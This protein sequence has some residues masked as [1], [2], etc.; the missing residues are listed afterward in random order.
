MTQYYVIEVQKDSEGNFGHNVFYLYDEDAETARLKGE[1]KYHEVLAAAAI[2]SV[3][4][5]A[6]ILFSSE[7][8]PMMHQCYYH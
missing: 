8:V 2:S 5:H 6:A 7:G 1:S 3:A 4:E